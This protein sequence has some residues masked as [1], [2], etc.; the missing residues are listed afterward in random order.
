MPNRLIFKSKIQGTIL[1]NC[2]ANHIRM[3][4]RHLYICL[5]LIL[6]QYISLEIR[7]VSF[8]IQSYITLI[9]R[10]FHSIFIRIHI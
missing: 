2:I 5:P 1:I 6:C 8:Y 10:Y 3:L 7:I 4:P 9:T